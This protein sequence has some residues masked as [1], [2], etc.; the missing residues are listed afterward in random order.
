MSLSEPPCATD[1]LAC[2][3][4]MGIS[5]ECR[6]SWE[7]EGDV[8]QK[9]TLLRGDCHGLTRVDYAKVPSLTRPLRP[10]LGNPFTILVIRKFILK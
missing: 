2:G 10:F 9:S 6:R 7:H 5:S 3:P 4:V 1:L 8:G